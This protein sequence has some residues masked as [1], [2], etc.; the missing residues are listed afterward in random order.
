M[1]EHEDILKN[2]LLEVEMTQFIMIRHGEFDYSFCDERKFIGH[3]RDLAPLSDK[4]IN[5]A[6]E[7]AED[8]R[9][10][11]AD[12]IVSSPYTR[13]LQTAAI[14]SKPL[15]LDIKV[16]VDLHEWLPD[17]TFQY[18]GPP[19]LFELRADF[20]KNRGIYP[21]GE[22]RRWEQLSDLRKRVRPVLERYLAYSKIIV[23][24]HGMAMRA[25]KYFEKELPFCGIYELEITSINQLTD[26]WSWRDEP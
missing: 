17:L 7:A 8:P 16:E 10:L 4:G 23:V 3:G 26:E 14:L 18:P 13:A 19:D 24:S 9:L 25:V 2:L 6:K 20:E 11:S 5:Q 22:T 15:Q 21:E 12:L 1:D